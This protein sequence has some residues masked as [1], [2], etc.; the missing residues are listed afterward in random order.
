MVYKYYN[1]G[2]TADVRKPFISKNDFN[3]YVYNIHN[4]SVY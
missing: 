2:S 4:S 3:K 1:S